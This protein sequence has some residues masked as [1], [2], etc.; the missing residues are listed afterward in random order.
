MAHSDRA[1]QST[2]CRTGGGKVRRFPMRNAIALILGGGLFAVP[3]LF[4]G[5][6]AAQEEE[7]GAKEEA[8]DAESAGDEGVEA[9]ADAGEEAGAEATPDDNPAG[10]TI[11]DREHP[12]YEVP[13]KTYYYV[14]LRYRAIVVPKFMIN[15]FADGGRTV[16]V[17]SAG[18]EFSIRKDGFESIFSL[19]F[20][21]YRMKDTAFRSIKDKNEHDDIAWELVESKV[22]VMYMTADFLWSSDLS[23]SF[24]INYGLGAGFGVVF[25]PV[26]RHEARTGPNGDPNDPDSFVR[27]DFPGQDAPRNWCE[28]ID[29]DENLY[30][31][32]SEPSWANGGS[33]PNVF[34]WLAFQTGF[35]I[36]P[37]PHFVGRV[38]LGFGTS[39]FFV[40]VG[41]DYGI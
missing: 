8:A 10:G 33:K 35:R 39:G 3:L 13:D 24:A 18:P 38:D 28:P 36:K 21:N 29:P 2:T 40:G 23:P 41:A 9:D 27:C 5:S 4:A 30:D 19:W 11:V 20:A 32:Y 25:G 7:E 17:H 15:L 26:Y 1:A 37:D 22:N 16:V 34:P 14:G 6:V 31:N 12:L